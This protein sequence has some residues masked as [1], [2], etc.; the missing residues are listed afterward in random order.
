[1]VRK[2]LKA[3]GCEDDFEREDKCLR[4]LNRLRHP[5][6]VPFWGSYTHKKEHYFLF[7]CIETDLGK[8]L[9]SE[10]RHGEFRWDFTFYAALT[11]LAS[12][13]AKT[14]RL[15]LEEE[16]HGIR[17]EAIGYHH[18]L[19][20]PNVLVSH[21]SFILA[22]FGLGSLKDAESL[23]HTP[24]KPISGDYIA[25][26]CTNMEEIPQ[27]VNRAI[28]VWAFGCLIL[29]VVTYML[30]GLDGIKTFRRNR[31]TPGRL[32]QW[33]DSGFY[34]PQAQGG[35]K[36]E[37][38]DW[39]EE[40]TRHTTATSTENHLLKLG[41]DALQADP[42]KRP[43]M[44]Q[45]YR[46]LAGASMLKHFESVEDIFE[47]IRGAE[48]PG[49]SKEHHHLE[50][51]RLAQER[52][53]IWGRVLS[54]REIGIPSRYEE[55]PGETIK[56]VTSLFHLLQEELEGRA[57]G[58]STSLRS[59][60][61]N[62]DRSVKELWDF[63][64]S[65]LVTMANDLLHQDAS[66]HDLQEQVLSSSHTFHDE[67]DTSGN[68][69]LREFKD[70][71]GS[72]KGG[73]PQSISLDELIRTKSIDDVYDIIDDLQNSQE[74]RNLS[75]MEQCLERLRGYT[76]IMDDTIRGTS[77]YAAFIW[78]P[79]GF[80]LRRSRTF[81]TAYIAV[82]DATAKIGEAL[83]DFHTPDALLRQNTQSKEILVL[84]FKDVLDFYSVMLRPFSQ[85][86]NESIQPP[87]KAQH[88]NV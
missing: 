1:M 48:V 4:L 35:I 34:K 76:Q 5:N 39:I 61:D 68:T 55:L 6:I 53:V 46:R 16:E 26:E 28:D 18:D 52:F 27:T 69:L 40:L 57:S 71:A 47:G 32:P 79:L 62:M 66:G 80:L 85:P 9:I 82:I 36:Q 67:T 45:I 60:Q 51:L 29:E 73:L 24:Y 3:G 75:K 33:K 81:D 59:F 7:P 65:D 70:L 8:F 19:R 87:P 44:D 13:L 84:L 78:G 14:H 86:G 2:R 17:V 43:T 72:F 10:S 64:P 21:D 15:V 31:L 63:L 77:E 20:P 22:D 23:S 74:L 11:G 41:L 83:P 49:T 30:R 38:M 25:P 37:V 12:A 56:V 58:E 88:F 50:S 42:G 54:L